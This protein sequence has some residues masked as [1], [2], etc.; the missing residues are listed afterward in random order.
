[1]KKVVLKWTKWLSITVTSLVVLV[2]V[3]VI[4]LLYT[5]TGLN[6]LVW[7][8]QKAVPQLQVE[9]TQG[10][11]FPRFTLK[12]VAFQDDALLIKF[13]AQSLTLAVN[14]SCFLEPSICI[15]D[16]A[17]DGLHFSMPELA[18]SEESEASVNT[19]DK[20]FKLSTP[21]PIQISRVRLSNIDLDI[22]QN[23]V[24][25]KS[26]NTGARFQNNQLRL[27]PTLWQDI[28]LSLAPSVDRGDSSS[29]SPIE[30][31]SD[32]SPI[33]LP[34][35]TMPLSL[36]V[37]R[38]DIKQFKLKQESPISINHLGLEASAS[39]S[40]VVIKTLDL[41]MPEVNANLVADVELQGAYP[42][43]AKLSADVKHP[44]ANGQKIALSASGSVAD[45]TIESQLSGLIKA[46]LQGNLKPLEPTLPYQLLLSKANAQWPLT[47]A[48][49]YQ[50]AIDKLSSSGSLEGY[51]LDLKA[52]IKGVSLPDLD[53]DVKGNGNLEQ[54]E[55]REIALS[56]LGG[57]VEGE[58]FANWNAPINWQ[59][60]LHLNQIQP[61]LYW[62][63]AEG[64]I[65]GDIHTQGSLTQ[66]GG[67]ITETTVIDIDGILR[68]YPLNIAGSLFASDKEGKG[69]FSIQTP[70]LTLAHGPNSV[71][72][73]GELSQ[74]WQMNVALNIPDLAKSVPDLNGS[75]VGD[76]SLKGKLE[77]PS[78]GLT[79]T[80][81]NI[82]WREESSLQQLTI[83]G[84]L[85][86]LPEPYADLH[87]QASTIQYQN[88]VVDSV[89]LKLAGSL[90][91]HNLMLEVGSDSVATNLAIS[92][93]LQQEPTPSWSGDLERM[94]FST[95]QGQWTLN[96]S[97]QLGFDVDSQQAFVSAHCW[98][99]ANASV[100]LDN[101]TSVGKKGE[102][103]LSVNRFSFSQ[104]AAFMPQG[105][106]VDGEVNAQALANWGPD[107]APEVAVNV[108]IPKGQFSGMPDAPLVIGWNSMA[109]N[110]NL[111]E[112][113]LQANWL[114]DFT[115]NGELSGDITIP[116]IA[117]ADKELAGDIR[118]S[119]IGLDF[120][121]P[122]L[123]EYNEFDAQ[124]NS[125]L[126]LSG[127]LAQP[128]V[129][130]DLRVDDLILKGEVSPLD[131]QGGEVVAK[132]SGTKAN[133]EANIDT[134]DGP[135]SIE[136]DAN[137]T[138]L[139]AWNSNIRVF[140]DKLLVSQPPMIEMKVSPD[141]TISLS[142]EYAKV[143]GSIDLPWGNIVVEELP[144]SAIGISKDQVILNEQ[145]EPIDDSSSS[146]FAIET[147]INISI[148]DEFTLSAFG[149]EG[150]LVG[151][152][153]VT[154]K[155][156]GPII[157][158]EINIVDGSY[159]SF[160]QELVINEGKI[161]MNGPVDQPY[162]AISAIRNPDNTRDDVI[163]G[164]R[165][166]GPADEP[167]VTIFSEPAMPQANALSYLL[168]GQDIDAETGG[169]AM[170]TTLI[171]LSLA[172]S[173]KVV[174]EIGEAF[175]VQDL[176]LDTAGSG[177]DSQVT[178]SGYVLPG[179]QVKYG[180]GIFE[181][182]GEFT[183]R[184][185]LMSDLYL[186]VLSGADNAVDLLYQ[187][188]FK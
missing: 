67:W 101:D 118:V 176:Q 25:W 156:K 39:G 28:S 51:E 92:G 126:A 181:S 153:N 187:F 23:R 158:G 185:R 160:G 84:D 44:Q 27:F 61:G 37:E 52:G 183:V 18:E 4:G 42:L 131:I 64:N 8:A 117:V 175:G 82:D 22:L 145:L 168:R 96:K 83:S 85:K 170:T 65:S 9:S 130:G 105:V 184:Y 125:Q 165:V 150:N 47:G 137:W 186:E 66:E 147:D 43:N 48:A 91:D 3:F 10:S 34:P 180:V 109:F 73:K 31:N 70:S 104:L 169:N 57:T 121:A 144:P 141:M 103:Q 148:G 119:Q 60:K 171:G 19:N 136:G 2:L 69:A 172:K 56:T 113:Q 182:I 12:K 163:A 53:V 106:V 177:E 162:V 100:C 179:L 13:D 188:E 97:T 173:G 111:A 36:V 1:M 127:S 134:P 55:L 50:V 152:L 112:N 77:E 95:E 35:F 6:V 26:L 178:V 75:V 46:H 115:D 33:V 149:L 110:A 135:L 146:I 14:P 174:G 20:P 133:L 86:P 93:G 138:D 89:D 129:I 71:Q 151:K 49:D 79:L 24:T 32:P 16:L 102:A 107:V 62:P 161:L 59:G 87:L 114:L 29:T 30:D 81:N 124:I 78:I 143:T 54:I 159:R 40:K 132:F 21:I 58:V 157:N 76:V 68:D 88:N 120:L 5:N 94:L 122:L 90:N 80:A 155:D 167:S 123:G 38:F 72:A 74:T 41:D 116:N 17:V 154:Q 108:Q 98:L 164:V 140:A 63:E 45:L 11:V 142:P 166:D 128:K 7:G 139:E 15:N 99:Q